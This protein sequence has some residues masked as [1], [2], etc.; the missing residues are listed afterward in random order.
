MILCISEAV[1]RYDNGRRKSKTC[2]VAFA[3]TK[4][5]KA[6]ETQM[7]LLARWRAMKRAPAPRRA[8]FV[9]LARLSDPPSALS[10]K[11]QTCRQSLTLRCWLTSTNIRLIS[12]K[13]KEQQQRQPP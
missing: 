9:S 11:T 8:R 1:Y 13:R 5:K 10:H 7:A 6:D 12:R 3:H 4:R 2:C